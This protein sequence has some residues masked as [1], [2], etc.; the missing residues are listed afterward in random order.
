M[1]FMGIK[2][3]SS[4]MLALGSAEIISKLLLF[5]LMVYA[6]RFLGAVSYGKF[7]FAL[8]F[9]ML[10]IILVDLGINTFL[11]REIARQK[12]L[13]SKY[14]INAFI[15]K[16]FLAI[17]TFL[18]VVLFLNILNYPSDT[19]T[20]VYIIWFFTTLSTFT[21]LLYS[22]FRAFE[23][24]WFDAFLKILRTSLLALLG[25]YVL[26]RGYSLFVFSSVFVLT[27]LIVLLIALS[28]GFKKFIK[29]KFEIE[30]DFIKNLIK[31]SFPFGLGIIFGSIYFYIGSVILSK[32]KGD[33]EV[34]IY[35]VAYYLVI[36]LLFIP[37]VY[38]NAIYPVLSRNFKTS[39]EKLIFMHKKSFKYL[40]LLGLPISFGLFFLSNKIINFFYGPAYEFSAVALKILSWFIFIKFINFLNGVTLYS[41]D[42]QNKRMLSQGTTAAFNILLNIILIPLFGFIGAAIATLIS[43]VVLFG[44]YYGFVS[45]YLYRL[46]FIPI[47][48]KPLI[49]CVI[50]GVFLY[51]IDTNLFISVIFGA[52]IYLAVLIFTKAFEKD[53]FKIFWSIIKNGKEGL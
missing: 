21:D 14:F 47:L 3:I 37:T 33:M 34:G 26:F 5:V 51:F 50:M 13:A 7:T 45:K 4:N 28:I 44:F 25:L 10:T 53:D 27:E 24:M 43:E 41:I 36:A 39:K 8:A 49:A 15:G 23:R 31:K 42:K 20:I 35:S 38:T 32:I 30:L 22:I 18:L 1:D 6:A 2:R 9:S 48:I 46:N 40:Y 19:K 16:I 29:I 52:L 17:I 11:I 12:R